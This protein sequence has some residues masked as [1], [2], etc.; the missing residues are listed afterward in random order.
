VRLRG[1]VGNTQIEGCNVLF[2][3]RNPA[4]A[5]PLVMHRVVTDIARPGYPTNRIVKNKEIHRG[6]EA[7]SWVG[8]Y[9]FML[10]HFSA[11]LFMSRPGKR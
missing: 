10:A 4:C 5:F 1:V 7:Y 6:K 8:G 9:F 3:G 2:G 11:M